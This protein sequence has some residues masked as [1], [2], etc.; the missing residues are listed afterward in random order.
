MAGKGNLLEKMWLFTNTI[1]MYGGIT[2]L[3]SEQ[4]SSRPPG[5]K[6]HSS[7]PQDLKERFA[8]K[9]RMPIGD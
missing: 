6:N 8:F 5:N 2:W 7:K 1:L 3:N 9:P 4:L